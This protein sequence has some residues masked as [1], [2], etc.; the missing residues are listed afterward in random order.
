MVIFERHIA[1][2]CTSIFT[3]FCRVIST[4]IHEPLELREAVKRMW[5]QLAGVKVILSGYISTSKTTED[6]IFTPANYYL[7]SA[8]MAGPLPDLQKY[9]GIVFNTLS[10]SKMLFSYLIYNIILYINPCVLQVRWK[11]TIRRIPGLSYLGSRRGPR[12]CY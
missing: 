10:S 7:V 8:R 2:V 6:D 5:G 11:L 4:G 12:G 1:S 3:L 9:S